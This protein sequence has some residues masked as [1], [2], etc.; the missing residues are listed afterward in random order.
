MARKFS[1]EAVLEAKDRASKTFSQSRQAVQ[2]LSRQFGKFV[3]V[4]LKAVPVLG[5]AIKALGKLRS[6]VGVGLLAAV[7]GAVAGLRALYKTLQEGAAAYAAQEVAVKRLNAALRSADSFTSAASKE[8]QHFANVLQAS[9]TATQT[10]VL[11][12]VALAKSFGASNEEAK[13]LAATALDFAEGAGLNATEAVR[14]LG[15]AMQ[16]SAA[17]VANFAPEIRELTQAQL[18]LGGATDAI[19]QKFSGQAAAAL[20][21]Y[22]GAMKNLEAAQGRLLEAQGAMVIA[23][24]ALRESIN[25]TARLTDKLSS[26]VELSVISFERL[27]VGWQN[28]QLISVGLQLKITNLASAWA[29]SL[30]SVKDWVRGVEA[31]APAAEKAEKEFRKLIDASESMTLNF[32]SLTKTLGSQTAALGVMFRAYQR[33][34]RITKEQTEANELL[35]LTLDKLG[36][37]TLPEVRSAL[38]ET[39][40][41][42][43]RVEE[44]FRSGTLGVAAYEF[45]VADL[46][47]EQEGLQAVLS[48]TAVSVDAY[49]QKIGEAAVSEDIARRSTELLTS[50]TERFR[51]VQ[52]GATAAVIAG[53]SALSAA[54]EQQARSARSSTALQGGGRNQFGAGGLFPGLSGS[55]YVVTTTTN[56]AGD[57]VTRDVRPGGR[58]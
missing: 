12:M 36:L 15:R 19:S 57:M 55:T 14:R 46:R 23:S 11:E 32:N 26:S 10:Q 16:G 33:N 24:P 4:N 40:A 50:S 7:L 29:N 20:D 39:L 41:D 28:L 48:G 51:L 18:R 53:N 49:K 17:D 52:E 47:L 6:A 2:G 54:E 30:L 58:T 45:A 27:A 21:T 5:T 13:H 43:E 25:L 9:T 8:I 44:G 31:A 22:A 1:V 34:I 37:R 35:N 3:D 56:E 42:L 38:D